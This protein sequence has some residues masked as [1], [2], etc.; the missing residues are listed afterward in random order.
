M[1]CRE[2]QVKQVPGTDVERHLIQLAADGNAWL[3]GEGF[4]ASADQIVYDEVRESYILR[5]QGRNNARVWHS[6]IPGVETTPS[7][8][9]RGEFFPATRQIRID[10]VSTAEGS[11]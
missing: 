2:L 10:A 3:E 4:A 8:F 5:G 1:S 9:Q 11:R 6:V 7:T